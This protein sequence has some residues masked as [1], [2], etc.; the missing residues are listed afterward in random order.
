MKANLPHILAH[1]VHQH[2]DNIAQGLLAATL[3][4]IS[5]TTSIFATNPVRHVTQQPTEYAHTF[6]EFRADEFKPIAKKSVRSTDNAESSATSSIGLPAGFA[7]IK[8]CE[9]GSNYKA[10]NPAGY[11]GAYQFNPG[12]WNSTAQAAG[13]SDLVGV[14]PDMASAA[15]QDAMAKKLHSLRGWQPWGCAYKVGLL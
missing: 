13:R 1:R 6:E 8:Q 14:R 4:G 9:S 15:D 7:Q 5:L 12:T 3:I 2:L 11:Y 10:V